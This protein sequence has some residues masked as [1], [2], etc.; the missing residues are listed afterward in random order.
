MK[1]KPNYLKHIL[2]WG[3]LAAIVTTVLWATFSDKPVDV[4]KYCPFGGLQAFGTYLVNNSLACSMSMLQIMMG[5]VLAAGVILFSKLFC[6]YLCPLGTVGEAMGR[7]GRKLKIQV[8]VPSGSA[9]DRLLRAVKYVLLFTILYFTLSSSELFCKKL[10]PYYAVATGFQG[11]IV[12]WMSLTSLVLL[13]LGGFVVRMFWCRYICPLGAVS[14]IFKFTVLLV[15]AAVGAWVLGLLGVEKAWVWVVG[16]TCAAAYLIEIVKLR[17]CAFPLMYVRRDAALCNNCGLCEKKCPYRIPIHDYAKVKHVDCTMCGQCISSCA[18]QAL[19]VNG[20][21]SWRWVP[22]LLA[23]VLFLM[24]LWLGSKL[25]LPTIDEKWGQYEQAEGLRTYEM[26]GLQTIKCFGSSK[27]FSA[28]MQ[29]VP[30]VYGVKTFVRRHGIEVLYDPAKTDTL[31]IQAAIFSPTLR[32]FA[33]PGE[34]I[35]ELDVLKLG[36]EGLHDRM[37]MVYFG[38]VLQRIE[39]VYG[40]T[41][42]FACP[43]DVTVYADPAA[44]ITEKQLEEAIDARELVIPSKEGEKIIPMHTVLKTYDVAGRISREEFAQTMF[45][46]VEKLSGRFVANA[47]KWG[48]DEQFPKA[49][50]EMEFP[51]I[52]KLPIRMGFPYFKSFLSCTDGIVS[53]DF[54]LRDLVPVMRV[55]Y[56]RSMWDDARLWNEVFQAE[57][58]TVRMADGTFKEV[59]PR[60]K[61]TREGRTVGE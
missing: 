31:K 53:V 9:A 18:T 6:G 12:L 23:I 60:L 15:V 33:T 49:V 54:V 61:F 21:R 40:F 29:T 27:A 48:D 3:V 28:K 56:V 2:Q 46:E 52:E 41:T 30:G 38:M 13:L 24:A 34:H 19:Q 44:G 58:W 43:V 45:R 51:G 59:D 20:R 7:A 22:G 1:R 5:L 26:E 47:E 4:E 32:K 14:N 17:S 35:P 55:H 25:E 11:E 10:D 42:E 16:A 50:Y 39:G 57:K 37:D 8:E 36:V